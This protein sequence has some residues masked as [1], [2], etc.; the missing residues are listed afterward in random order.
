MI[1]VYAGGTAAV[2]RI[3]LFSRSICSKQWAVE[4][5]TTCCI[6]LS[7]SG[8]SRRVTAVV[9]PLPTRTLFFLKVNFDDS[10]SVDEPQNARPTLYDHPTVRLPFFSF[11]LLSTDVVCLFVRNFF[12]FS[13]CL[14]RILRKLHLTVKFSALGIRFCCVAAE[15]THAI[16]S[17]GF[18][19]NSLLR[20]LFPEECG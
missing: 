20:T 13:I 12:F 14:L 4:G 1:A 18:V 8:S 5:Q 15:L 11:T 17:V 10:Q 9:F 7:T 3:V 19:L 2:V 16:V 6:V